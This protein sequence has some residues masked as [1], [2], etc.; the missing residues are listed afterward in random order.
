M[1][2]EISLYPVDLAYIKAK[3]GEVDCPYHKSHDF[4]GSFID[5]YQ[6][7]LYNLPLRQGTCVIDHK[8]DGWLRRE[9]AAKLYE[10][11]YFAKGPVFELGT[12]MG[13]SASIMAQACAARGETAPVDT[14]DY[15]GE[16]QERARACTTSHGFDN[17]A[18]HHSDAAEWLDIQALASK[19]YAFGF[20]DHAHTREHVK[21]ACERLD[22]VLLPGSFVAFHDFIDPRN[23][24]VD[25][26]YGVFQG[27][28][29]GLSDRFTF[30][31]GFGCM[32]VYWFS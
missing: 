3:R 19:K 5:I 27:V 20:I 32:G 23:F 17:I 8:I 16:Q 2:S 15:D 18:F 25:D 12:M 30:S 21:A 31:G 13:L 28:Q 22:A 1:S 6:E 4:H 7:T 29:E 9:D 11:A 24:A 14:V 10:L 26:D